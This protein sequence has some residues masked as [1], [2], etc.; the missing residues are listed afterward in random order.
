MTKSGFNLFGF[1]IQIN[2]DWILKMA[3]EIIFGPNTKPS[4]DI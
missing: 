2:F 1:S 4:I 3:L